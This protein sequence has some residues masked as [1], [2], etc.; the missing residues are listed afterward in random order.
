[1]ALF[2][3][4]L[5]V[6]TPQ[7][8]LGKIQRFLC[9]PHFWEICPFPVFKNVLWSLTSLFVLISLKQSASSNTLFPGF[10][11]PFSEL[12][13]SCFICLS[14]L[15]QGLEGDS[16]VMDLIQSFSELLSQLWHIKILRGDWQQ[17]L[18]IILMAS[19]I[20]HP[21]KRIRS[22]LDRYCFAH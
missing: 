14:A 16:C 9:F 19:D 15:S 10:S 21:I 13:P 8:P 3:T 20:N 12:F 7:F 22:E 2:A 18:G 1:M 11:F 4:C 5:L 6:E 17:V